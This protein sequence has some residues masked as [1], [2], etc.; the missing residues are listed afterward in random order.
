[1]HTA[2]AL[3]LA[4]LL[5][6]CM[7][8]GA[9]LI[10][11]RPPVAVAD[12]WAAAPDD[13]WGVGRPEAGAFAGPVALGPAIVHYDGETWSTAWESSGAALSGVWGA[14]PDDVWAVGGA[15][16][17]AVIVHY[18]GAAWSSAETALPWREGGTDEL[19]DVAGAGPDDV[20][21]V[22]TTDV[23]GTFAALVTR[24]DGARWTVQPA[25]P[26]DALIG[27][28]VTSAGVVWALS[29]EAVFRRDGE[30]WTR[31]ET[32]LPSGVR[33]IGE[34]EGRIWIAGRAGI[35]VL[36]DGAFVALDTDATAT[37]RGSDALLHGDVRVFTTFDHAATSCTFSGCMDGTSTTIATLHLRS[38][39]ES[40]VTL[41]SIELEP[42]EHRTVSLENVRFFV[43]DAELWVLGPSYWR[44]AL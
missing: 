20:W 33:R 4:L 9:E 10:V 29:R 2:K 21:A 34:S 30:S 38:D 8:G 27:V 14:A 7:G 37:L 19:Y 41:R 17:V 6:G 43:I 12:V 32:G 40:V 28:H 22:G 26:A 36:E 42:S 18:D 13:A 44:I 1:M 15:L 5:A 35:A 16:G 23:S 31:L 11:D 39:R 25:P 3:P 24:F